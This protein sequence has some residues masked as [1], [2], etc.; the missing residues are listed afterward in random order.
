MLRHSDKVVDALKC[1]DLYWFALR[2]GTDLVRTALAIHGCSEVDWTKSTLD[3][4]FVLYDFA[5]VTIFNLKEEV[6]PDGKRAPNV[7]AIWMS[8]HLRVIAVVYRSRASRVS[9]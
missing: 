9:L 6:V 7:S 4:G 2:M 3:D 1:Y 5:G 8:D